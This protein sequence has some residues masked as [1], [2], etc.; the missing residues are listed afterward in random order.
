MAMVARTPPAVRRTASTRPSSSP[1]LP[2]DGDIR[3]AE[4]HPRRAVAQTMGVDMQLATAE[5]DMAVDDL[6]RQRHGL[7]DEGNDKRRG[8]AVVKLLGRA[9]LLDAALVQNDDA[10]GEFHR[11]VLVMSDEN[12][13]EPGFLMDFAQPAAQILSHAGVKRAERLV[14]Q[15]HARLDGERAGERHALALA[16]RKLRRI[17]SAEPIELHQLQQFRHARGDLGARRTR[18]SRTRVEA[19]GDI[20]GHGH[21]LEQRVVLENEAD[22]PL[23][24]GELRRVD[25]AKIHGAAV[26]VFNP[27]MTR[28]SVVL[29]E[30]E[31]PSSATSSPGAMSS[32]TSRK[33]G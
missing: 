4:E 21:M 1:A 9:D 23:P 15:Q 3:R 5:F 29:P 22:P 11:L 24:H 17:A 20:V 2:A 6:D 12:R 32:E 28:S 27:A 8:G 18:C 33:A 10:I 31:G 25:V 16:A 14:E 19:E 26:G 30:P 7:A 13:G